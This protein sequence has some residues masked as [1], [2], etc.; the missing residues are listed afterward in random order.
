MPTS[1]QPVNIRTS[2]SD[3][4]TID[5]DLLVVPLFEDD[6]LGDVPG[7]DGAS[8]G[9]V[10]AAR[11][12]GEVTGKPFEVFV[13]SLALSGGRRRR[14]ALVGAGRRADWSGERARRV[15]ATAALAARQRRLGRLAFAL[16]TGGTGQ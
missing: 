1:L 16:R 15:A 13:S 12:R 9:E 7:L 10:S 11:Q 14:F 5:T 2:S 6:D 4:L 8:G 3:P